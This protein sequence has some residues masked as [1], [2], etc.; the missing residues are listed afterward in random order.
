MINLKIKNGTLIGGD[1]P[2][3]M[4]FFGLRDF[5][6]HRWLAEWHDCMHACIIRPPFVSFAA[7]GI[8]VE[9]TRINIISIS[10]GWWVGLGADVCPRQTEHSR[11]KS[12]VCGWKTRRKK[13]Q[14]YFIARPTAHKR[15]NTSPTCWIADGFSKPYA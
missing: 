10:H 9:M 12:F 11:D 7:P 13:N 5:V 4:S 1:P 2:P 6:F 3:S 8:D 14:Y 15:R